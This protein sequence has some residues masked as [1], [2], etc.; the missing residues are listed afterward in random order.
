MHSDDKIDDSTAEQKKLEIITFYNSTKYS[1]DCV[2][3]RV[4]FYNVAR[5]TR[6]WTMVIFHA[7]RNIAGLNSFL[8]FREYNPYSLK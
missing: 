3:E 2:N 1:V 5:Y 4:A 7:L 6:R 8:I